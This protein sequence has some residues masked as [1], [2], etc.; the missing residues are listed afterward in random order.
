MDIGLSISQAGYQQYVIEHVPNLLSR[1][2]LTCRGLFCIVW[3]LV[4]LVA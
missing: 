4:K 1:C 3:V 2:I